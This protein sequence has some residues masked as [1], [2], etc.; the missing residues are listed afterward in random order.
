MG[1]LWGACGV[2]FKMK[3][4][5]IKNKYIDIELIQLGEVTEYITIIVNINQMD[6]D[7]NTLLDG[8][9]FGFTK[10]SGINVSEKGI[11]IGRYLGWKPNL[12]LYK[13]DTF[14]F[15]YNQIVQA[16]EELAEYYKK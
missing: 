14:P 12:V 3:S 8:Y 16:F 13:A 10:E 15:N 5:R 2:H 9:T 1:C 4:T 6:W 11:T 7:F